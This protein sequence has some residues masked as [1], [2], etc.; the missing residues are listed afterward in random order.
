MTN[1]YPT[2]EE[3]N[4]ARARIGLLPAQPDQQQQP[5]TGQGGFSLPPDNPSPLPPPASRPSAGGWQ[6]FVKRLSTPLVNLPNSSNP[7]VNAIENG[8]ENLTSPIGLASAA[9]IP[10]TGGASLGFEGLAGTAAS[11]GTRLV[12]EAA[13]G[14]VAGAASNVA[15]DKLKNAPAA[16][17]LGGTLAA[18][19]LAGGATAGAIRRAISVS[20]PAI[21]Q[22]VKEAAVSSDA[23]TPEANQFIDAF[24]AAKRAATPAKRAALAKQRSEELAQRISAGLKQGAGRS[25]VE[26]EA[27]VRSALKGALSNSVIP[28]PEITPELANTLHSQIWAAPTLRVADKLQAEE[29]LRS[30]LLGSVP[31]DSQIALMERVWGPAFASTV[32]SIKPYGSSTLI[33]DAINLPRASVA[34]MDL[35]YPMNQGIFVAGADPV[36]WA[37]GVK[38]ST[39]AFADPAYAKELDLWVRGQSGD[40]LHQAA[41]ALMQKAGLN[42]TGGATTPE[43]FSASQKVMSKLASTEYGRGL[44]A[45]ERA[46]VSA[47]NYYRMALGEKT[48][49][50]WADVYGG[51]ATADG[52]NAIPFEQVKRL[53][54]TMNVLTGRSTFKVFQGNSGWHQALNAFFFAPN[55]LASRLQAPTL[56]FGSVID[57][58]KNDASVLLNPI[59]LYKSDPTLA[60]QFR[61]LGGFVATAGAGL[62][63]VAAA[64]K[65][66]LLPG[67]NVELNPLSSNFGKGKVGPTAID[68]WGGYSQLARTVA[69]MGLG[70]RKTQAGNIVPANRVDVLWN[71]FI[72]S[73]TSPQAGTVWNA[74][75]GTNLIG[76]QVSPA[77]DTLGQQVVN[78][79]MPL[80]WQDIMQG[81]QEGGSL[82]ATLSAPSLLGGRVTNFQ[83]LSTIRND[84][85]QQHFS[86]AYGDLT[87]AQKAVVNNNSKVLDKQRQYDMTMGDSFGSASENI[88]TER[89]RSENVLGSLYLSGQID[90]TTFVNDLEDQQLVASTRTQSALKQYN[91]TPA[92]PH[93]PLQQALD[94]YYALYD[95]ADL[96]SQNGV[97]TGSIDWTKFDQLQAD[98]MRSLTPEQAQFIQ[99]SVGST[100]HDPSVQWYF[101]N[102]KYISNSGYYNIADQEFAKVASRVADFNITT[103]SQLSAAVDAAKMNGDLATQRR[104]QGVL[105]AVDSRI[106]VLRKQMRINDPSLDAALVV[107]RGLT[108]VS[109]KTVQLIRGAQ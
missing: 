66:G 45:S 28:P 9:F 4:A 99:D 13:V 77:P 14:T 94:G 60:L 34:A 42:I 36:L 11:L 108:P 53:A 105:S 103:Y 32:Q 91:I 24:N 86:K 102:K 107:N 101:D 65:A 88:K 52:L 19:A 89:A 44:E 47:G 46:F 23:Y 69:Q 71:S 61:A 78:A 96:G 26:Q 57:A 54:D 10:V 58:A 27:A 29:G 56:L 64:H 63:T 98:Y 62:T 51:G 48:L 6:G 92:Q 2:Q 18:G 68:F 81:Y 70:E 41:S 73:K 39:K 74:I 20:S 79:L 8:V 90:N 40:P 72:R 5:L 93:S 17:R 97:A 12:A 80:A 22:A 3:L 50:K 87:P 83:S 37:K 82:G 84:V 38:E 76:E 75:T 85:A 7:I 49:L 95:Q 106:G 67:F 104:L 30:I 25:S 59:A 33:N 21:E 109:N 43:Y 31:N 1:S 15:S 35:S 100:Q 55:F 16:V